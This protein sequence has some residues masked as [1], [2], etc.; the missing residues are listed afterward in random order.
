MTLN[1]DKQKINDLLGNPI[2]IGIAVIWHIEDTAKA[3]FAVDNYQGSCPF[4]PDTA[5]R[6]T[7]TLVPLRCI[8]GRGRKKPAWVRAGDCRRTGRRRYKG[9]VACAGLRIG[10]RA[11]LR[12][13]YAP[14]IAA[15]MLQRQQ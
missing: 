5:L 13:P 8:R 12:W 14:E 11:S 4:S 9:R 1:N 3:V 6:N 10:R 2:V 7:V 15:A